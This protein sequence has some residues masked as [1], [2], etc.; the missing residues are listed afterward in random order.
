MALGVSTVN[1]SLS[2]LVVKHSQRLSD[3]KLTRTPR[4]PSSAAKFQELP[5]FQVPGSL[6]RSGSTQ[7]SSSSPWNALGSSESSSQD[8]SSAN[9]PGSEFE[10]GCKPGSLSPPPP[11]LSPVQ[12]ALARALVYKKV[13][14]AAH[15][16]SSTQKLKEDKPLAP[17]WPKDAP[18]VE[19]VTGRNFQ[20]R[21]QSTDSSSASASKPSSLPSSSDEVEPAAGAAN[22]PNGGRKVTL[23]EV[24][25][26]LQVNSQG[27]SSQVIDMGRFIEEKLPVATESSLIQDKPEVG[28][29][30]A[31]ESKESRVSLNGF[32]KAK[33]YKQQQAEMIAALR[34]NPNDPAEST[35][36]SSKVSSSSSSSGTIG[37]NLVEVEIVTR[38]GVVKK[39]VS[40]EKSFSNV[41]EFKRTGV[42][43]MDFA[44][45]GFADKKQG[46]RKV[47]HEDYQPP[48]PGVL[49]EVEIITKDAGTSD[50]P[51][52]GD[53]GDLYKPKVSTWGLFPRPADIS[54]TYGGGRT[55]RPGD[56]LETEEERIARE[57]KTQKLLADYKKKMGLDVD[58]RVKS[59]CENLFKQGNNLMESGDLKGALAL[60]QDVIEKMV[61]QSEL[62][63]SAA[64]QKAIC[65]DSLA[66]FDEAREVYE[67]LISHPNGKIRKQAR[68]LL[69]GFKA[70]ENLKVSTGDKWDTSVYAK[71]FEAFSDGYNNTYKASEEE[72]SE[73]LMEQT[74][75]Y[76]LLLFFPILL[77]V[78]LLLSKNLGP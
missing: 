27:I 77:V 10:D 50:V 63:G 38:E 37:E 61:F 69:Y 24:E 34:G 5:N 65:L 32:K 70:M 9:S 15:G 20:S 48:P 73:K 55:I 57:A 22:P 11:S 13:K 74:L 7:K 19:I 71:Y 54:K 59:K 75:A 25:N 42:S 16:S 62:H 56:V 45:L 30:V 14:E 78:M 40:P 26:Q 17:N 31:L 6:S 47:I 44:G 8:E 67:K 4:T 58:P 76:S 35:D 43:S 33:A 72:I 3:S 66:R 23:S 41:K 28:G 21:L 36:S 64:L 51:S 68:Q 18:D 39:L 60:F 53:E 46:G 49:P 12:N 1:W 2:V 29:E 52:E